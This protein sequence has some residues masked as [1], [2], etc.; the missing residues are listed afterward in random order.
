MRTQTHHADMDV[1]LGVL[2]CMIETPR[3]NK[4]L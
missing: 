4:D 1:I 2:S 3:E